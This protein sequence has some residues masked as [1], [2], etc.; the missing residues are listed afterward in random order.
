[1][2]IVSCDKAG[3]GLLLL[4]KSKVSTYRIGP[5]SL[6]FGALPPLFLGSLLGQGFQTDWAKGTLFLFHS[7]FFFL[8]L[9]GL[10]GTPLVGGAPHK[11]QH[12]LGDTFGGKQVTFLKKRRGEDKRFLQQ[13]GG[14]SAAKKITLTKEGAT[15]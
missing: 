2:A 6:G 9:G 5:F 10:W 14:G 15:W 8:I 1:V 12:W 13:M 7:T 4:Y 3:W 11:G